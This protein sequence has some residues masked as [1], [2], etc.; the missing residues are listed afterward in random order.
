MCVE[1]AYENVDIRTGI[2]WMIHAVAQELPGR[3][4]LLSL[5]YSDLQGCGHCREKGKP[6]FS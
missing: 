2:Y 3:I 1:D 4:W 5:E 6:N